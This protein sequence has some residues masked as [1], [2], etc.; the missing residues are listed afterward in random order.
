MF[1][2]YVLYTLSSLTAYRVAALSTTSLVL[3]GCIVIV[4]IAAGIGVAIYLRRKRAASKRAIPLDTFILPQLPREDVAAA[5]SK[6]NTHE[7]A[8]APTYKA[9]PAPAE[10]DETVRLADIQGK[11][12][13][14]YSAKATSHNATPRTTPASSVFSLPT[15]LPETPRPHPQVSAD[16][17]QQSRYDG[18]L[19]AMIRQAQ[20]GIFATPG[21]DDL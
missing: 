12:P 17:S 18:I 4:L 5:L 16:S 15:R 11:L 21:K 6:N 9:V 1:M 10:P 8:H 2:F 19:E 14:G 7:P 3:V 13:D 20:R